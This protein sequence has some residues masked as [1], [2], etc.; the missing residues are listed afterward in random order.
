MAYLVLAAVGSTVIRKRWGRKEDG[1]SGWAPMTAL[2]LML[3]T[4]LLIF[5]PR[6]G[7]GMQECTDRWRKQQREKAGG[8]DAGALP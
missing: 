1:G 7:T 4:G 2:F 6:P 5:F 8:N 3:G